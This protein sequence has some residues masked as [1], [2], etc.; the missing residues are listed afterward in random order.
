MQC[1]TSN[2]QMVRS[3][4]KSPY[5]TSLQKVKVTEDFSQK[6]QHV[7]EVLWNSCSDE[8]TNGVKA[9]LVVDKLYLHDEAYC[10]DFSTGT[11][12]EP[13]VIRSPWAANAEGLRNTNTL[14]L[15]FE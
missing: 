10:Q 9:R 15:R 8:T 11:S 13:T 7:R 4:S 5:F 12:D 14:S 1:E 3:P 2:F 6:V